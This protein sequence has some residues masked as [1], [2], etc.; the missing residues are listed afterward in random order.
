MNRGSSDLNLG[1]V[2]FGM[3]EVL[4][5]MSQRSR[6]LQDLRKD[7]SH[8]WDDEAAREINSRYLN[9]HEQD[10]HRMRIAMNEQ[11]E[12]LEQGQE[13]L[14]AT[15]DLALQVDEGSAVVTEKLRFAEQDLNNSYSNFDL[16]VHY[17]SEACSRFP[18]VQ[19][20][21]S[22]ANSACE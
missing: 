3:D 9:L 10:D 1:S 5:S 18:L 17:N 7:I 6:A 22:H 4:W 21:L 15:K 19:E 12:L 11:C 16:Y 8:V 20:L 2:G 14:E 13:Q